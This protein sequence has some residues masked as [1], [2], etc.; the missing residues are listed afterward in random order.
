MEWW[1]GGLHWDFLLWP[2]CR[3]YGPLEMSHWELQVKKSQRKKH[4]Y[5]TPT[6][7]NSVHKACCSVFS[8]CLLHI[9]VQ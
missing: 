1:P 2:L 8:E 6:C 4:G 3:L 9:S 5:M 7:K